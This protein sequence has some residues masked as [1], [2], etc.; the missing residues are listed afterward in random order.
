MNASVPRTDL[1][2]ALAA[3]HLA[4]LPQDSLA[5]VMAGSAA[6][7]VPAGSVTHHEGD[8]IA[9]LELVVSGLAKVFVMAPDGR[10]ATV[11]YCRTG[12]LVGV[13]SL[14]TEGFTMPATV[15]ALTELK[16]HRLSPAVVRSAARHDGHVAEALLQEL[17]ERALQFMSEIAGTAFTSVRQRV[18]R[19]LLDLAHPE[20]A[21][22]GHELVVTTGQRGLAE[23]AGTA[24]EV[25]VRVLREFRQEQIVRTERDRIVL[26]EPERLMELSRWNT[27][28]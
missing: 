28:S 25:I 12:A 13:V 7:V 6:A 26:L 9:H 17:S 16:V 24:R 2:L 20:P 19:H 23:A 27:G 21:G 1:E 8:P 3:S 11:R 14:F 5:R 18:A 22:P 4:P 10:T 15:L